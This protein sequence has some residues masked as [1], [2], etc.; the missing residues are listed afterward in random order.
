[1]S[2]SLS[3]TPAGGPAS[4]GAAAVPP[5]GAPNPNLLAQMLGMGGGAAGMYPPFGSPFGATG[6]PPP[7]TDSRPPEERFQTQLQVCA[8]S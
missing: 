7:P 5:F 4:P 6:A 1:M 2:S 3:G 8:C